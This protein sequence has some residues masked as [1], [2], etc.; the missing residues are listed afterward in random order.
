MVSQP[1]NSKFPIPYTV[2]EQCQSCAA[3]E[4]QDMLSEIAKLRDAKVLG[5]DLA[6]QWQTLKEKNRDILK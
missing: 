4:Y 6:A 5:P 2:H 3:E 1:G